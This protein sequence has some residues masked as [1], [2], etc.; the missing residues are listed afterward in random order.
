MLVLIM[1]MKK[2]WFVQDAK[3]KDGGNR[4]T[5]VSKQATVLLFSIDLNCDIKKYSKKKI[6]DKIIL[7]SQNKKL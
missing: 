2:A 4:H 1:K 3:W 6:S 7:T 5:K